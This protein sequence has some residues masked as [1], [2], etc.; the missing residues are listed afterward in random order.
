MLWHTTKPDIQEWFDQKAREFTAEENHNSG[1]LAEEWL[2]RYIYSDTN[3]ILFVDFPIIQYKWLAQL[4]FQ[5]MN[6]QGGEPN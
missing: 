6:F 4:T 2:E 1:L 3:E 5:K